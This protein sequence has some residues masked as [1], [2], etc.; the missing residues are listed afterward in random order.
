M[1]C[2]R[3]IGAGH[4]PLVDD[5]GLIGNAAKPLT[6]IAHDSRSGLNAGAKSLRFASLKAEHDLKTS[7]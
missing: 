4:V 5:S 2:R 3:S 6:T 7:V 1:A